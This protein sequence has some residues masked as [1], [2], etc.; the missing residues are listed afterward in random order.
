MLRNAS[1]CLASGISIGFQ[2]LGECV[3]LKEGLGIGVE[4]GPSPGG[5]Y[6]R[7]MAG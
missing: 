5:G 1:T 2:T 7:D 4:H 6:G 3:K